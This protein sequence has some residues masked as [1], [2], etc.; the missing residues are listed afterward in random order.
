MRQHLRK[1]IRSAKIPELK[2][3]RQI[4]TQVKMEF[5]NPSGKRQ[6]NKVRDYSNVQ[7]RTA[8]EGPNAKYRYN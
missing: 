2:N 3:F 4:T 8:H 6:P 7:H 5:G 1:R